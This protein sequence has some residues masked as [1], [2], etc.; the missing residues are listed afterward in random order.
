MNPVGRSWD[1]AAT[2]RFA[3]EHGRYRW[4]DGP[5]GVEEGEFDAE[6]HRA[7]YE[8]YLVRDGGGGVKR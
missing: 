1:V 4:L 7:R 8:A 5:L 6:A 2:L 3:S